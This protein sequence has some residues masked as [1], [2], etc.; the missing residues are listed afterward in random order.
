MKQISSTL[1]FFFLFLVSS[2]VL[3]FPQPST[4]S[5]T[6]LIP[7]TAT[8][9]ATL[10][11][12]HSLLNTFKVVS[13]Q[14]SSQPQL[15]QDE[16]GLGRGFDKGWPTSSLSISIQPRHTLYPAARHES[17][18][19]LLSA[20]LARDAGRVRSISL[21]LAMK[22][23]NTMHSLLYP[24]SSSEVAS[25][26]SL[27]SPVVSGVSQ[28][29]GEYFSR[30]SIGNPPRPYFMVLDTG[31]DVTWL[32]CQPCSDCYSQ[33]DPIYDPS[34]SSSYSALSCN[35]PQCGSLEV[36][37]CRSGSCLYQVS[38]GDGSFTVG[39][40]VRETLTFDGSRRVD[41][42]AIG[43]GH[44]NEGLFTGS[45]G[46]LGLGGGGLSLPAQL[47]SRSFSY[48]LVNRD[49]TDSSTLDFESDPVGADSVFAPLHKS[50]K[51]DTFY[52]VGLQGMNVG[53]SEVSIQ[54]S[55]FQLDDSGNGG[56]IVDS[57]TAITR[58]QTQAYESL[59]DAFVSRT[60]SL[61]RATSSISL[62]DTCYDFSSLSRVRVPTVSFR[63]EG[64]RE[65]TLPAENYLIPVDSQGTFCFAFAPTSSSPSIIGNVQQQ[66]TRVT[67][68]LSNSRV[69]FTPGQ[70]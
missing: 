70:C 62:F 5:R 13:F 10:N 20:R 64:G 24:S 27:S 25:T 53:G 52:Y 23:S 42:V 8:L 59:R 41:G 34:A 19:S 32:Q 14:P 57:G 46:L 61:K 12:S 31:S 68:D 55:L 7:S 29:S 21:R 48:C 3:L 69:G 11:V 40:F 30:L 63:F 43:C 65:W 15:L 17:Y 47:N 45:A 33:T 50:S 56:V 49:S 36:S 2:T 1:F 35:T 54:P 67:Y 38:Y 26:D 16:E 18:A 9:Y 22:L 60:G 39:D 37:A 58:L 66:G 44:D 6:T 28:G 51:V 4:S